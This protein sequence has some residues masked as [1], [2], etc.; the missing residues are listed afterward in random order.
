MRGKNGVQEV[1]DEG[2][3][4]K[5]LMV[6]ETEFANVLKV[7]NRDGNT[8]SGVIRQ[9]Y[10]GNGVLSNL[11][12]NSAEQAT[13]AH[14]SIIGHTTP[15]DLRRFLSTTDAANG[16]GNRFMFLATERARIIPSPRRIPEDAL[17]ELGQ[18]VRRLLNRGR[19]VE[20]MT[21]TPGA[22]ELWS[23]L[24][25]ELTSPPPGLLGDLLARGAAHVT[26]LSAIYALL[27]GSSGLIQEE[28][29]V[30]AL[31]FW[32]MASASVE[33]VF[34]GRT[35][36]DAADRIRE[37]MSPGDEFT[38][39]EIREEV[40]NGRISSARLQAATELLVGLG[41]FEI[42]KM[43]STGGRPP[44]VLRRLTHEETLE[45]RDQKS[46]AAKHERRASFF[47]FSDVFDEVVP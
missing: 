35:G 30:S 41:E 23:A 26:R 42:L 36:N 47:G 18:E 37:A 29:V 3:A 28:H 20:E 7:S 22:D 46:E 2:V 5:R 4:D 9:A 17:A 15:E 32:E 27:G 34:R 39:T 16:F 44:K 43:E 33:I 45:R 6:V 13:E 21:R 31:A 11:S 40:F 1:Q 24:Y 10:D 38:F 14:V 25:E 12:K 8:L 19:K